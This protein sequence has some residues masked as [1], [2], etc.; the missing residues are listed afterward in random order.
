M[1]ETLIVTINGSETNEE[2]NKLLI[3]PSEILAAGGTV[4]FPTETVYGLGASALSEEAVN[5]IYMAKG[6]PSDNP[7][8]VHIANVESL[9]LLVSEVKPYAKLL[10]A[11][12]WPGPITFI[13][14][15][16]PEISSKVCGGLDTI[17]VRMPA[18]KVALELIRMSKK[19][20]AAPSANLSGKPSPTSGRAVIDDMSG[21]VDCIIVGE[22]SE[23][24]LESTVLDVTG[25]IP[26]ILR[27]GKVTRERIVELVG[28]CE[29]D[30]AIS[31]DKIDDSGVAKSPGMKY[32]HYAPEADMEVFVG[33]SSDIVRSLYEKTRNILDDPKTKV[34]IMTFL[35]EAMVIDNM[36]R[37]HDCLNGRYE[38]IDVGSSKEQTDYA[39]K[40]FENLRTFDALGCTHILARGVDE[41][42]L[43]VAIMNRLKK[44]SDGKVTRI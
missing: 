1:K 30:V 4:A 24:G 26:M 19:P 31:G 33:S 28:A 18:H 22:N 41:K 14:S 40:L 6:R 34:G 12:L 37:G 38:W 15:K 17:A 10:M 27:P 21:R 43:G 29:M 20:I 11:A 25:D 2:L 7:L 9:N 44:A 3:K 5:S 42:G 36:L 32:K 13:F 35:E 23:V 16:K 39:G 8:I